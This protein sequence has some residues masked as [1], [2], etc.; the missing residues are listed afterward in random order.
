MLRPYF[1]F[2][3]PDRNHSVHAATDPNHFFRRS[4][5]IPSSS[6]KQVMNSLYAIS[7]SRSSVCS[8]SLASVPRQSG[9]KR[10]SHSGFH[11]PIVAARRSPQP[12][13]IPVLNFALRLY[14]AYVLKQT[15]INL[16]YSNLKFGEKRN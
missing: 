5:P 8:H 1:E 16:I 2:S 14:S 10:S 6:A 15:S 3:G 13:L 4:K 7:K 12:D 11:P 9:T